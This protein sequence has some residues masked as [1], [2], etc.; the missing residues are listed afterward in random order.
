M[1]VSEVNERCLLGV[2][3]MSSTIVPRAGR[4]TDLRSQFTHS[5]RKSASLEKTYQRFCNSGQYSLLRK[6][7]DTIKGRPEDISRPS[8]AE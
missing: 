6:A 3:H 7:E 2:L 5:K 4:A 1:A 8:D